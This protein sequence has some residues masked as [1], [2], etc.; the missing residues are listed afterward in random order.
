MLGAPANIFIC[1]LELMT[2]LIIL[3]RAI[4]S[5]IQK[6]R[7]SAAKIWALGLCLCLFSVDRLTVFMNGTNTTLTTYMSHVLL[8]SYGILRYRHIASRGITRWGE[9]VQ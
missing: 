9:T 3:H 8:V 7:F 2:G 4:P 5:V 1:F 6:G